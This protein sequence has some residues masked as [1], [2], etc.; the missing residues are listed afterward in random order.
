MLKSLSC[1]DRWKEWCTTGAVADSEP[2]RCLSQQ[3]NDKGNSLPD[4]TQGFPERQAVFPGSI[5]MSRFL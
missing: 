4:G 5:V 3:V 2:R 1:T